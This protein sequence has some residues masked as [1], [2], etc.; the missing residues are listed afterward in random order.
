MQ[1]SGIKRDGNKCRAVIREDTS[2]D[3]KREVWNRIPQH[4][5]DFVS[6]VT[7]RFGRPPVVCFEWKEQDD[8]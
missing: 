3:I 1:H 2:A 5:K 6:E 8:G 4:L 7:K